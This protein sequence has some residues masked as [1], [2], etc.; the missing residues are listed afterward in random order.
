MATKQAIIPMKHK[1]QHI[2]M[3][4]LSLWF[5][6]IKRVAIDNSL[7]TAHVEVLSA[8]EAICGL[9]QRR[10]GFRLAVVAEVGLAT[11]KQRR[12]VEDAVSSLASRGLV[13]NEGKSAL[14][15]WSPLS[16]S[17]TVE[18]KKILKQIDEGIVEE[19]KRINKYNS[20]LKL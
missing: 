14:W 8:I 16:Y 5:K 7:H 1:I 12:V 10:V 11:G 13:L 20:K 17:L 18:G 3:L 4:S 2:D 19:Q 15:L 9:N 6:V